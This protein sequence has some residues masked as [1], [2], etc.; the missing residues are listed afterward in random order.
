MN[1]TVKEFRLFSI[2]I[3]S[4][5]LLL[6]LLGGSFVQIF[7]AVSILFIANALGTTEYGLYTASFALVR[8]LSVFYNLG[9]D[10]YM[11]RKGQLLN[12]QLGTLIMTSVVTKLFLGLLWGG[13]LFVLQLGLDDNNY[14]KAIF[15]AA[16]LSVIFDGIFTT[17][18]S[19]LKSNLDN[20]VTFIFSTLF[21]LAF[22]FGTLS[23]INND[24]A[25]ADPYAVLRFLVA[26]VMSGLLWVVVKKR[27]TLKFDLSIVKDI[28]SNTWYYAISDAL[29]VVYQSVDLVIITH[30]I[31]LK[32]VGIY[33]PA[34]LIISAM[35]IIPQAIMYLTTPIISKL[36]NDRLFTKKEIGTIFAGFGISGVVLW[37]IVYLFG[38]P[39]IVIVLGEQYIFTGD[40]LAILSPII[41]IKS[42]SFALASIIIGA[43]LQKHR[44]KWQLIVAIFNIGLNLLVVERYGVIG[45]SFVFVA[46]EFILASGYFVVVQKWF[47]DFQKNK[48]ISIYG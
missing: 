48:E 14:P 2:K 20:L 37:M 26:L 15:Y 34:V 29:A 17:I 32:M 21:S 46:S 9:I 19:L 30:M 23:M 24:I 42:I 35:Y 43:N 40:V 28:F 5:N 16:T 1:N 38:K 6:L 18:I 31:G 3:I 4:K 25:K 8:M 39:L 47:I 10:T 45:V 22:F 27:Y 33:S 7:N 11:L 36:I 12:Q 13:L 44:V 41:F